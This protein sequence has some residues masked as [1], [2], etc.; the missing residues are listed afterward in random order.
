MRIR[1]LLTA[2]AAAALA[3][4][5]FAVP[6]GGAAAA[7]S[8][9][10]PAGSARTQPVISMTDF[11]NG[12]PTL[13]KMAGIIP[14]RNTSLKALG[15]TA[16][17]AAATCKE[18][19]CNLSYHGAPVQ[20]SP[21]VYV[22]FWGSN[23]TTDSTQQAA[24]QYLVS[25]YKGLGA[26]PKDDWTKIVS[27]YSDK[28][29][30]PVLG[31]SLL[32]GS[33]VD[34]S[35]LPDQGTGGLTENDLGTEAVSAATHFKI[36]V[37][38]AA[39]N[40]EIVIAIQSGACYAPNGGLTF[41]GDCG[42]SQTSGYCAYHSYLPGPTASVFLPVVVLPYQLDAGTGCG[43]NFV[44]S[45]SAG[46]F[47]GFSVSGG[48]ETAETITDPTP[49]ATTTSP[50][51]WVD[52]ADNVSGGEIAD[53]CA[54]RGQPWSQNPPD[55]AGDVTLSTGSFAMQSLWSNLQ[56]DCRMKGTLPFTVST[57]ATQSNVTG[58]PV[59][60]QV[61]AATSPRSPLTFAA[62]GL[63]RSLKINSRT[64]LISGT[65]NVTAGIFKPRITVSY[66][67]GS[68]S[69]TFTWRI[70]SLPGPVKG[71]ASKCV[72]DSLGRTTNGNKIDISTC[73]GRAQQR[74]AFFADGEL[75]VLG[76]CITGV[77]TAFLEPCKTVT[78]Q[79]WTRLSDG[80]YVLRLNGRCLTDPN[81]S[82]NN[83]TRLTLA[84]CKNTANQR[85][86][87]P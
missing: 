47:D 62:S 50:A 78:S 66:Y 18:P 54:W 24:Q 30:H 13:S 87:L 19:N 25:F 20:H 38:A 36:P 67:D 33:Y 8:P 83:G 82:R 43:E 11:T 14:S 86:T 64:G 77:K 16:T 46:M 48:H 69:F 29:G 35:A 2:G 51:G 45:G 39:D 73:N 23:W 79:I 27:Q 7:A 15:A 70:S 49:P 42:T 63:P 80:Q 31:K 76:K 12:H 44:N 1:A 61:H 71:F 5:A 37:T 72:D 53:K 40:A 65:P 52:F 55:P 22:V 10:N 74:I 6:S 68:K 84:T 41:A 32:A 59:S 56:H 58:K 4:A 60:L 28:T 3:A 75:V 81:A 34:P 57:L 21:H 17:A 9:G 26:S 85:W